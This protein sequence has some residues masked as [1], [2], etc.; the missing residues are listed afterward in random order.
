M[1][2]I[3]SA[4]NN[5]RL[6]ATRDF[7]VTGTARPKVR[8]YGGTRPVTGAA[9]GTPLLCEI[10]LN[11]ASAVVSNGTLTIAQFDSG[12]ILSTG[13]PTWARIVNGSGTHVLDCDAGGP[14][15]TTEIIVTAATLYEGGRV[16]LA[17]AV[18]G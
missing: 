10:E 9:P 16:L 12:L 6:E 18:F 5:A 2:T 4:H 7:M 3:S 14:G 17:S 15:S 13:S 8:L 1:I 11:P